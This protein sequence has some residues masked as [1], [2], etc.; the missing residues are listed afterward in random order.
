MS[1][2]LVVH[3]Y[4]ALILAISSAGLDIEDTADIY[5]CMVD[6]FFSKMPAVCV[7]ICYP[8]DVIDEL[9]IFG[10]YELL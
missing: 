6:S 10:L 9:I 3:L 5:V 8:K 4:L 7:K 2:V 1:V